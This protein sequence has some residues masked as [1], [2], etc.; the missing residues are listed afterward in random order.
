MIKNGEIGDEQIEL[1]S[2]FTGGRSWRQRFFDRK[3]IAYRKRTNVK[4]ESLQQRIP[5]VQVFHRHLRN[6]LRQPNDKDGD[7]IMNHDQKFGR[8]LPKFRL[9]VDQIRICCRSR[10]HL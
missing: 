10:P 7:R 9:N 2:R 6:F 5:R 8:F 4:M 3:K 1:A